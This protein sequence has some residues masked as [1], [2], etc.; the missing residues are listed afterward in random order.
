MTESSRRDARPAGTGSASGLRGDAHRRARAGARLV[1]R[2]LAVPL[3]PVVAR[4]LRLSSR[5]QGIAVVYHGLSARGGDPELELVAPHATDVFERQVRHLARTYRVVPAAELRRAAAERRRGA[6]FPAAITFDDDLASHVELALPI[7]RRLGVSATFCL[8]GA[9][10]SGPHS[11]W[12]QRLQQAL[13]AEPSRLPDLFDALGARRTADT[14]PRAIHEL[15]RLV[16]AL[17]VRSREAFASTLP[18][19]PASADVGI[20]PGGVHALA[21][22]GMAI[23]LHTRRHD[24]LPPLADDALAVAFTQGRDELELAAG[25]RLVVVAY[26][27]GR[28]D[29]RVAG[30]ARAAGFTAGYTGAPVPVHAADDP[31]LLG[32]ITPSHRSGRH[33]AVQIVVVLLRSGPVAAP[34]SGADV[35][36]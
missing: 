5:R 3:A 12:W 23:G 29:R 13:D 36:P 16:E 8:T 18:D 33:L 6:R 34:G 31:L 7:L 14:D 25:Q 22:A 32:R 19:A 20:S 10:L 28:A 24:P 2:V 17:D 35:H 4:L 30:V 15:A 27:H 9:T 26:P 1:L 21:S 11:F